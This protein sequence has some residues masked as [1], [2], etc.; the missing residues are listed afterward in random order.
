MNQNI[1]SKTNINTKWFGITNVINQIIKLNS[2]LSIINK[3]YE[4]IINQIYETDPLVQDFNN[5]MMNIN[6]N[7][8]ISYLPTPSINDQFNYYEPDYTFYLQ[9][10]NFMGY[11]TFLSQN[12]SESI[13]RE[14][15]INQYNNIILYNIEDQDNGFFLNFIHKEFYLRVQALSNFLYFANQTIQNLSENQ[16]LIKS[17]LTIVH[18]QFLTFGN[19]LNDI[20]EKYIVSMYDIQEKVKIYGHIYLPIIYYLTLAIMLI[21]IL[22]LTL[23]VKGKLLFLRYINYFFWWILM[24]F[25]IIFLSVGSLFKIVGVGLE[26]SV[27][28]LQFL[29]SEQ[30]LLIDRIII[31]NNNNANILNTCINIGGDVGSI[32]FNLNIND[33]YFEQFYQD[34]FIINKI[35][36]NMINGGNVQKFFSD[37]QYSII[38]FDLSNQNINKNKTINIKNSIY[39]HFN[40]NITLNNNINE[41]L[42][43]TT[44]L[45][46]LKISTQNFSYL[47]SNDIGY[48]TSNAFDSLNQL[49]DKSFNNTKQNECKKFTHDIWVFDKR[50]CLK[51]YNFVSHSKK[52]LSY[53]FQCFLVDEWSKIEVSNKYK[54]SPNDCIITK[55]NGKI[56]SKYKNFQNT[57]STYFNQIKKFIDQNNLL[58]TQL[59]LEFNQL[60]KKFSNLYGIMDNNIKILNQLYEPLI[61]I[62]Y[63]LVGNSSIF[64]FLN[65]SF[66]L[67]D[68]N[69]LTWEMEEES[70]KKLNIF[71]N[72]LI[73]TAFMIVTLIF[74]QLIILFR[75]TVFP[76]KTIFFLD[77]DIDLENDYQNDINPK[78]IKNN[79]NDKKKKKIIDTRLDKNEIINNNQHYDLN[80]ND[81]NNNQNIINEDNYNDN[82]SYNNINNN[83]NNSKNIVNI[84]MNILKNNNLHDSVDDISQNPKIKLNEDRDM[85]HNEISSNN[86]KYNNIEDEQLKKKNYLF[87]ND[88]KKE[89]SKNVIQEISI[90]TD[91][92]KFIYDKNINN[93]NLDY[94]LNNSYSI[95]ANNDKLEYNLNI[96]SVESN[97][98]KENSKNEINNQSDFNKSF[99]EVDQ[100][101]INNNENSLNKSIIQR[102]SEI[103]PNYENKFELESPE[104]DK[105]E[106]RINKVEYQEED[107]E[108]QGE[109]E[110][111][112]EDEEGENEEEQE[113][114]E[115]NEENEGN[116]EEEEEEEEVEENNEIEQ[117][118]LEQDKIS[119]DKIEEGEK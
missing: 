54:F 101:S 31:S 16:L 5:Y 30:N 14:F 76:P 115:E 4:S 98:E 2:T 7:F 114:D 28:V 91:N 87:E 11:L 42:Q 49:T 73:S 43:I 52:Y 26:D 65:C 100:K 86:N 18:N 56:F 48:V 62:S 3:N 103:N 88:L 113:E 1:N 111:E 35:Y 106:K 36:Q 24:I 6:N 33:L 21:N 89:E 107:K 57:I 92:S 60:N 83:I 119:K 74:F 32:V 112:E 25:C 75:Y 10:K 84:E 59:T 72:Y 94:K 66:I 77:N 117:E 55:S 44:Y 37:N 109:E 79:E 95:N 50:Y 19:F 27:G 58:I 29:F 13:R 38:T 61:N 64:Q 97:Q 99:N 69:Y 12:Y 15:F 9:N 71:G 39:N 47:G 20:N 93:S 118:K 40:L 68:L 78:L 67:N 108:D 85:Y 8:G 46:L 110:N 53:T 82:N 34:Y 104:G 22:I 105:V 23:F 96:N 116:E 90:K 81:N 80:I 102:N 45:N 17:S 41:N 70:S 63:P 51:N